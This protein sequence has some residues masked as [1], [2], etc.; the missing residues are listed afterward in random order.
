MATE[1]SSPEDAKTLND[2]KD[3]APEGSEASAAKSKGSKPG[4]DELRRRAYEIFQ[5]RED[6][7]KAEASLSADAADANVE[8]PD[9][10]KADAPKPD[11]SQVSAAKSTGSKPGVDETRKRA[12]EVFQAR[13]GEPG[14]ALEDWQKAEAS[15]SADAPKADA[16]KADAPKADAPKADAPKADTSK[17]DAPKTD[18]PKA[19]APKADGTKADGTKADASKGAVK[20]PTDTGTIQEAVT[21]F[22]S[23]IKQG[24]TQEEAATRLK[25]DGPNAIKE[26]HINPI[27]RFLKF[28]WGP[29]AWM[30]EIAAILSAVVRHWE[31]FV[32]IFFM[33]AL[34]A[35]VGFWEEFKADN[36]IEALKKHL[37]M[38][39]HVL[40]D[41]K[42]SDVPAKNLVTGDIVMIKLG[43]VV[44]A[45]MK[46]VDGEYLSID[47][48]ALT[49]ESLPVQKK[50]NDVAYSGS[51]VKMG[52]MNGLV[53]ATGMN[54]LFGRAAQLTES[55][56][57]VSHFQKA[58][59]K[60]G[61][62]L[63]LITLGLV[64]LILLISLYCG[65]PFVQTILFCLILT[66]AAIPVALP[67]V[68]SV[69]MAVGASV[70]A[71]MKAIVSRLAAIEE[72]AGMDILCSDKTGTLT[73]DEL[74]LGSPV[75]FKAN[76]E[77][78]LVLAASLASPT[79]GRDG[80]DDAVV[81]GLTDQSAL[82]AYQ[83]THFTPFDPV[84]KRTSA[85]VKHGNSSFKVSKGAPQVILDLVHP[86]AD[87]HK[88]AEQQVNDL[89]KKGYRTLGV[90]RTDAQ[91]KWELLGL[92]SLSD[93]LR[94][95]SA[96]TIAEARKMGLQVR[97]VTGDNLA[98]AQE[99]SRELKLGPN[100]AVASQ[101]F[102]DGKADDADKIDAADGY[103][104]VFPEHKFKI[105]KALQA[106][107]H[108]VGMTGDGVNDAPALKK[109]DCGI[110]VSG[111][112]DA[113]RA[114]A[115]LVLT[116]KGLSVITAAISEAR[117]IFERMNSY[118]IYRIAE[119]IRVL[120]FMTLAIVVFNFYPVTAVMI[121]IIAVLNDFPIMMIAYDN[122]VVAPRPVRWDMERVLTVSSVL[123]VSGVIAVFILFWIAEKYLHMSRPAVQSLM[124]LKLL[125][126]G[127]LTIYITRSAGTF[128]KRPWPNWRLVVACEATQVIGTLAAV[129]GWGMTPLGWKYALLVWGYALVWFFI[130]D[131]AKV[132]VY[133]ILHLGSAS[134]Q[135]HLAR[136]NA[137]LHPTP[138]GKPAPATA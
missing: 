128:W 132:Q 52:Q 104:E 89:A 86:D 23:N 120:L 130:N 63:I 135:R 5:A 92:L 107:G 59:L 36:E 119:T 71:R 81:K 102:P 79:N 127:H 96:S 122:T 62:F 99:V 138:T 7:Q 11:V 64:A 82:K 37:A 121:V 111:A 76:N 20:V 116:A 50:K 10:P 46:L 133:K 101:L 29:I 12:F 125:V 28:L 47:Q 33:L 72:M 108:I 13:H 131:M 77:Q 95:D 39:S 100:I 85:E 90:A 30:I 66:V 35:V 42:W 14:S 87:E 45:D 65:D 113:A 109:A 123:G 60:I 88:K 106:G 137:N 54:T 97:M 117:K 38:H 67:A 98:I 78:D 110:A 53:T 124:F 91:G 24:L 105:V 73:K 93:T 43:N 118:A 31:D 25:K 4:V 6:L 16:P 75:V 56:K 32:M 9:T 22:K 51:I 58:V 15:V 21:K 94:D 19:D 83:V 136:I 3:S 68:L 18:A 114:A 80:I 57:T 40:R 134:H 49:G 103:A 115:D 61:N 1:K 69:T 44:P 129:Y 17:A 112:T 84:S 34:N 48:S 55:V 74:E 26:V 2:S 126:A 70:L 27:M 41:G 8:K